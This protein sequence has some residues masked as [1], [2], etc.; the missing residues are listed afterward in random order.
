MNKVSIGISNTFC[1]QPLFLFGTY[2]KDGQPNYSLVGWITY[3]NSGAYTGDKLHIVTCMSG[4]KLTRDRLNADKLFSVNLVTQSM[5]PAADYY[6]TTSGYNPDKMSVT[7]ETIS[8]QVLNVPV[9]KE[10]PWSFEV[11][12]EEIQ[13]FGQSDLFIC[14]V[15]NVMAFEELLDNNLSMEERMRIA[16]P[17][18]TVGPHYFS[19]NPA[20]LGGWGSLRDNPH[21]K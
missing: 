16:S 13:P 12:V 7:V 17:V 21:S 18:V 14:K 15:H 11:E 1:P 3:F 10:S 20:P 8:G 4:K 9:I 2:D 5:L 19:L 6:G